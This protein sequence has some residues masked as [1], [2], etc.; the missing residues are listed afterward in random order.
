MT[1]RMEWYPSAR[2]PNTWRERFN[3]AGAR[4]E[5]PEAPKG[6][7]FKRCFQ[8]RLPLTGFAVKGR[9]RKRKGVETAFFRRGKGKS[10]QGAFTPPG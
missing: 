8:S 6:N 4:K 9:E 1:E 7:L 10:L 3:F 5:M 2:F